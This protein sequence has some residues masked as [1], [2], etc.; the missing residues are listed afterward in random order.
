MLQ[1]MVVAH[2]QLDALDEGLVGVRRLM[3]RPG[4]QRRF[5]AALGEPVELG[6]LRAVRA[7]GRLADDVPGVGDV[8]ELL[9]VDASTASRLL[10]R[11][12]SEGYVDRR[13]APHDRRRTQLA[14]T[15]AG[16]ALLAKA[17]AARRE[18]LSEV[19]AGWDPADL[20]A[21]ASLLDRLRRDLDRLERA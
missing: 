16:A 10:D 14:L 13:S 18:L 21:L 11:A 20:D 7:V 4:Y 19:T 8:A 6:T 2:E 12:V 3:Q 15:D 5:L 9:M 17:D 1:S